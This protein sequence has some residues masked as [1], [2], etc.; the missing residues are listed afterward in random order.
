LGK[1]SIN[2]SNLKKKKKKRH[3]EGRQKGDLLYL[4]ADA[5]GR[6]KVSTQLIFSHLLGTDMSYR[7]K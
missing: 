4:S 3:G 7:F 6:G 2:L 1:L 5:L